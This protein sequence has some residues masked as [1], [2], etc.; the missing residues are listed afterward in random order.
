MSSEKSYTRFDIF[1]RIEHIVLILSFTTLGFT[2]LP[3]KY[4][5]SPISQ[6]LIAL[7]GGIEVIRI[8][9][10]TAATIFVLE[11]VYHIVVIGYKLYVMRR[12]ATML[13][14]LKDAT[15][16]MQAFF[17]NLGFS[18]KQP[19]LPRYNFAEKAE[20]WA[21]LWGLLVMAATGF[22]LWNPSPPQ[23]SSRASLSRRP[24]LPTAARLSWRCWQSSCG[25]STMCT[26][27][28]STRRCLSAA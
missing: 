10:R 27:N 12:E 20:Y 1:Q 19:R 6:W 4:A 11:S 18:R 25:I 14:N 15:D 9:H 24:R 2:G 8:I 3:Q 13:P 5:D 22:M 16:A 28:I 26:S 21:M 23:G 17:Y 7:V